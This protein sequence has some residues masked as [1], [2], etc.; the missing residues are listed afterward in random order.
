M[1]DSEP[2]DEL[3][4]TPLASFFLNLDDDYDNGE[5]L[6]ELEKYEAYNAIMVNG[7]ESMGMN[8]VAIVRDVCVFME[9]SPMVPNKNNK[10]TP[11]ELWYKKRPNL[12]Y[13]RVWGCRA[14]VRLPEPKKKTLGEN[15][16]DC[17]FIGYDEHSKAYRFYVIKPNDFIFVNSV[18]KSRDEIFDKNR[19]SSM[20]RPNDIIF[21]S[22]GTQAGDLLVEESRDEIASQYS[23]CYSIEEDPKT[24]DEAMKSRDVVFWKE[25]VDD[26]IRSIMENNT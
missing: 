8:L 10:T 1:D 16:I 25:A 15:G 18:I 22:N 24:F 13:L 7:L 5:V 19:F 6:S 12:S 17:I 3:V 14:V 26:E 11:Y 2:E 23:Y 20:P 9:A 4:N 21:S